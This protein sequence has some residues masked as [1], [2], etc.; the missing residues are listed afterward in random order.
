MVAVGFIR[1]IRLIR[2]YG[3]IK[4]LIG[5]CLHIRDKE[6]LSCRTHIHIHMDSDLRKHLHQCID[7]ELGKRKPRVRMAIRAATR[8]NP[9]ETVVALFMRRG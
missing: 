5:N 2:S 1:Q 6:H 4:Q 3:A 7:T 9:A 8:A